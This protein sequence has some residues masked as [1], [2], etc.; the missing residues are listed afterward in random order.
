LEARG[1]AVEQKLTGIT[2]RPL[3]LYEL[4][5]TD[6]NAPWVPGPGT[7]V[8]TLLTSAGGDSMSATLEG[9][10]VQVSLET[11]I[12]RDPEL[13]LLGDATWGGVTP[14]MVAA[15]GGWDALTAVQNGNVFPFDDNLVSRPGPRLVD[16]LEAL[17]KL[18]H[19]ELFK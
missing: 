15:R 14:E 18:L 13:I 7:F 9:E 3:V 10:W 17:A 11:I 1:S 4:D 5:G 2:E 19:P 8:N 12:E 16:G 6:P